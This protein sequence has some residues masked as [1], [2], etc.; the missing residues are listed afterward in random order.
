ML[1]FSFILFAADQDHHEDDSSEDL[2]FLQRAAEDLAAEVPGDQD[3]EDMSFLR[4]TAELLDA[5]EE[6]DMSFLLVDQA[7]VRAEAQDIQVELPQAKAASKY[8]TLRKFVND[9]W[10]AWVSQ[11]QRTA[12]M[13]SLQPSRCT[14]QVHELPGMSPAPLRRLDALRLNL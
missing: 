14:T 13:L 3:L 12:T 10:V 6:L 4:R 11:R 9:E 2:D 1:C 7:A 8:E 5:E